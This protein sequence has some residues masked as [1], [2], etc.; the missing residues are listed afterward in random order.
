MTLKADF[1]YCEPIDSQYLKILHYYSR[2]LLEQWEVMI[3]P[4]NLWF[5]HVRNTFQSYLMSGSTV[6]PKEVLICRKR[7]EL[8]PQILLNGNRLFI[9]SRGFQSPWT[10]LKVVSADRNTMNPIFLECV[11]SLSHRVIISKYEIVIIVTV[12]QRKYY[13]RSQALTCAMKVL[14]SLKWYDIETLFL[15]ATACCSA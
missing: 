10:T 12:T 2:P 1:S 6:I 11:A 14:I 5:H 13:W 8:E 15:R 3:L 9:E 4:P 7:C